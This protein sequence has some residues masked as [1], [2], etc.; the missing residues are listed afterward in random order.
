[1]PLTSWPPFLAMPPGYR[2]AGPRASRPGRLRP[3]G[4][5]PPPAPAASAADPRWRGAETLAGLSTTAVR[6]LDAAHRMAVVL[7]VY[8]IDAAGYL[9]NSAVAIDRAGGVAGCNDKVHPTRAEV[10]PEAVVPG[11]SWPVFELDF[12]KVGVMIGHDNS[13]VE[14]A[15][16]LAPRGAEVLG[17]P[18]VQS[19]RGHV[20]WDVMLRSRAIDNG[21]YLVSSCFA[22]LGRGAWRPG[23]MV[24]RSGV[25][26]QVGFVLAK[27]G[28]EAGV[29][30]ATAN[31]DVSRLVHSRTCDGEYPYA[32]GFRVD[33]RPDTYGAI[34]GPED[35]A[36]AQLARNR[37]AGAAP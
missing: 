8:R 26:G 17:W 16:C 35:P 14:A 32:E 19:V 21:V 33:R 12:G 24:G 25:V 13:F 2:G 23:I 28:R 18:H 29:A 22:M 31:L 6:R 1:M 11:D 34:V 5:G 9:R 36:L 7:P 27:T 3:A 15:R 20:A 4:D 30:T 10:E 37:A